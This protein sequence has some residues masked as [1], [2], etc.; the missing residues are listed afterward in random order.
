[1]SCTGPDVV[2]KIISGAQSGADQAGL[3]AAVALDLDRGGWIPLGRRTEDGRLSDE[4]FTLWR[5]KEHPSSGWTGRTEQNIIDSDGT[6]IFGNPY[7]PGSSLTVRLCRLPK[8]KKPHLIMSLVDNDPTELLKWILNHNIH[9]LNVA[10]NRES[11]NPGI[12][13]LTHQTLMQAFR[14]NSL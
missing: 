14:S 1:M 11:V 6:V 10:G 7:T 4:L 2:T 9:T 5:L 8:H 13:Q 3:D 12:Y